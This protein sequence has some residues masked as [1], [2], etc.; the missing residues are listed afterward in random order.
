MIMQVQPVK[1]PAVVAF[2]VP[3]FD[4]GIFGSLPASIRSEV[5]ILLGVMRAINSAET[6]NAACRDQARA[7]LGKRGWTWRSLRRKYY[8]FLHEGWKALVDWSRAG[9][10]RTGTLK[11]EFINW[12]IALAESNQRKTRPAWRE[13]KRQ[14]R[15]GRNITGLD[16][17]LPRHTLPRG[18]TYANLNR[19]CDDKWAQEA[20]RIGLGRARNRGPMVLTSRVGLWPMSHLMIDDLL[21]DEFVVFRG[22]PVRVL[23]FDALE[24]LS[25]CKIA[26]GTKP[27]FLREEDGKFDGLKETFMRMILARIFCVDGF[28]PRGTTIL[29]ERGTAAVPGWLADLLRERSKGKITVRE[30]GITGA[31]Q[32]VAGM[33]RGRGGGNPRWKGP[34][35]AL[36]NLIH[37]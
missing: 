33:A 28:S 36:R 3:P 27:K 23:E 22:K 30:A 18:C 14:W 20:M 24:L 7:F 32:A 34:L 26:W 35:E 6:V 12:F 16:N 15:E 29:A 1:E 21:H 10:F 17:S 9:C 4:E 37:N 19:Y 31:E 2:D 25:G 13:F 11:P 8:A 5:D